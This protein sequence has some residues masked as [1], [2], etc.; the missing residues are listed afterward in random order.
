MSKLHVKRSFSWKAIMEKVLSL[1]VAPLK[2][3]LS[4]KSLRR[5]ISLY[6][7]E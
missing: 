5:I 6:L 4:K 1:D 7:L 2:I 3:L